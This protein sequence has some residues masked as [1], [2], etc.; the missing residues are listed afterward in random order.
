MLAQERQ[1]EIAARVNTYGS[2]TVKD[3]A[4]EFRVTEDSIRKDLTLLEKKGLLKK[5]YGGAMKVRVNEHDFF[6][7]DRMDKH[8]EEK[9]RIAEKAAGLIENGDMIFLDISTSNIELARI[10][11]K[12]DREIT[13]VTT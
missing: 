1:N 12:E 2:V 10:L 7:S 6:V 9:K 5:T 3:L 4:K 8:L 13:V 11:I